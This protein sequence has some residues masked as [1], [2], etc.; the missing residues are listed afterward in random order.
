MFKIKKRLIFWA[1]AILAIL[2]VPLVAMQLTN[3]MNWGLGDFVFLGSILF[4]IALAYELIIRKSE[5]TKY[6]IAFG[7]G[8]AGVLILLLVNGVVGIIGSENNP[9]NLMYGA[10]LIAGILG[11]FMSRLKSKGMMITL[12][13]MAILQFLVP[14]VALTIEPA[15]ASWGDAGVIGVFVLNAFFVM[16]FIISALLFR[17]AGEQ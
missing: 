11:S 17:R 7:I 4:V 2:M 9:A 5:K 13:V 3:T 6:R 12:L 14:I 16:L 8:L 15:N 10:V 1:F